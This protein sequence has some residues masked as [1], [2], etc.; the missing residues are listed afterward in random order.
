MARKL[1]ANTQEFSGLSQSDEMVLSLSVDRPT[2][3]NFLNP[4]RSFFL[5][6]QMF[7]RYLPNYV[8]GRRN[9]DGMYQ[10]AVGPF[11]TQ[12]VLTFFTGYFQDRLAPRVS[13]VY[14]PLEQQ[15][16]AITGLSYRWND[17][18]STSIGYSNFFGHVSQAQGAYF[19]IAQYGSVEQYNGA[20]L[21][22][23]AAPVLNRDQ[24]ELRFRYTW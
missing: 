1:F 2:F 7:V 17:A 24:A 15:A 9:N 3:F 22:R 11:S 12:M 6:F 8:G 23:G 13:L 14:W 19:P 18:F 10:T 4:N 21:G 16:A 20:V 5:N